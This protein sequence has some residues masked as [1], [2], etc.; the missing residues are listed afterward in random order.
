MAKKQ[1]T[2]I[3]RLKKPKSPFFKKIWK[4]GLS[5]TGIG[6]SIVFAPITLPA[7]LVTVGSYIMTAGGIATALAEFS[8]DPNTLDDEQEELK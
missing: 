4:L 6:A 3:Q 2:L 7:A 5:L 1:P 8:V